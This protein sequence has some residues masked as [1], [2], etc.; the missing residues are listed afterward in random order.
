VIVAEKVE[1]RKVILEDP[2]TVFDGATALTALTA[3]FGLLFV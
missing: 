1:M 2:F 3:A